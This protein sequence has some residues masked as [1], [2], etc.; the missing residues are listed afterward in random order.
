MKV[1]NPISTKKK[2]KLMANLASIT[3]QLSV[4]FVDGEYRNKCLEGTPLIFKNELGGIGSGKEGME[5]V[6]E[7]KERAGKNE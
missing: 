4:A 3:E 2:A 6:L 7:R 5:L 1:A